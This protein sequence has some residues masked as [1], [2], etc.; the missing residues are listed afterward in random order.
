MQRGCRSAA[1]QPGLELPLAINIKP[2]L[3]LAATHATL[4]AAT[5]S[6][7]SRQDGAAWLRAVAIRA[8]AQ[9][10]HSVSGI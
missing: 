4:L 9:T 1:L 10:T 6:R 2:P 7:V 5:D 8:G 3:P